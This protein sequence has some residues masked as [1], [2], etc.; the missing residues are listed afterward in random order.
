MENLSEGWSA[1]KASTKERAIKLAV[2]LV[3]GM[4]LIWGA[5]ALWPKQTFAECVVKMADKAKGNATIFV[6][7]RYS[8]CD[9]LRNKA[10]IKPAELSN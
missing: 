6:Q 9:P 7:L 2:V 8:V 5:M 3:A 1:S 4:L 10:I